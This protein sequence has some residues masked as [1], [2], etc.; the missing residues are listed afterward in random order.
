M[1]LDF[2]AVP[3]PYFV[4]TLGMQCH[5]WSESRLGK[6]MFVRGSDG[7][8]RMGRRQSVQPD[9]RHPPGTMEVEKSLFWDWPVLAKPVAL[10]RFNGRMGVTTMVYRN[11]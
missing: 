4:L 8:N 11:C 5:V 10:G 2:V 3:L 7:P 9:P 6:T 1:D